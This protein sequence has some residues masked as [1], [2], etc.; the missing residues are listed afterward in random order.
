MGFRPCR[1]RVGSVELLLVLERW[2]VAVAHEAPGA[3]QRQRHGYLEETYWT[4]SDRPIADGTD[5]SRWD[6]CRQ[7][8]KEWRRHPWVLLA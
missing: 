8:R 2:L 5:G 3:L 4:F 6:L 7:S 1:G